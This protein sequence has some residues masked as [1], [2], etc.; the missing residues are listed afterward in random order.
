MKKIKKFLQSNFGFFIILTATVFAVYGKTINYEFIKYDDDTLIT[1]NI[2]FI[3]EFKNIPKLFTTSCYYS[4]DFTYYRPILTLSFA[5][6]TILFG[7]NTKI[8]H[9]SNIILF[10]LSIY[11]MYVFISR[12]K[13]NPVILK[14]VCLLIAVHPIFSSTVAWIP[15][16]NDTLL[17]I[18]TFLSFINLINYYNARKNLN[19]FLFLLFFAAALFTKENAIVV[20]PIY[21]LFMYLFKFKFTKQQTLKTAAAMVLILAGY[22]FI[23]NISVSSMAVSIF[24]WQK[25]GTYILTGTMT[26][27]SKFLVPDS[28]PVMI[29]DISLNAQPLIL[30][31]A[32]AVF[33]FVSYR[34]KMLSTRIIIFSLI[35]LVL[36][37]LPTFLINDYT[38]LFH[39]F[40]IPS[41]GL[42]LI[43]GEF[44]GNLI[45]KHIILKKY[46]FVVFATLFC[47]YFYATRIQADKYAEPAVFW[48]N[49][50]S[51]AP[52]YH[53]ACNGFAKRYLDIGDYEKSK[54]FMLQ[55]EQLC[56]NNYLQDIAVILLYQK[57][58]EQAE[59]LL[60]KSAELVPA[61]RDLV[62]GNLSKL[63]IEKNEIEKATLYAKMAYK[64]NNNI[65]SSKLLVAIHILNGE[66]N[67]A[68]D[69]CFSL[70]K[71]DKK[72]TQY[73]YKI[74][75]LYELMKDYQ[76]ALKYI[77]EG[78]KF[79]PEN[80]NLLEKAKSLK[81][82]NDEKN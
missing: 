60:F 21:A 35:W 49:A 77:E 81:N 19:L 31:M 70:L 18:F 44:T 10:I 1:R 82:K 12:L 37:L 4:D 42:A 38:L 29:Y 51:D 52:N 24:E 54:K 23:R 32:F 48:A 65:D 50:Y 26:Y 45:K 59:Q 25:Y 72:N 36:W 9:L 62:Y 2:N 53:V 80:I 30:N 66:F 6:E 67:K 73:Y 56:P 28:M 41:L 63:Y 64:L 43:F 69:M 22:F 57:E 71:Y 17:L 7:N 58:Y 74:G 13:Q 76:N 47:A 68:L 20:I 8:F 61:T 75:E 15:A 34:K 40:L 33:I 78:L 79:A 5:I 39:R 27:I 16:R 55:A 46:L 3:S 11:L 14:F